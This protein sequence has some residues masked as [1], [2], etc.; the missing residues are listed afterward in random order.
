MN[1]TPG[2][3]LPIVIVAALSLFGC[4]DESAAPSDGP[5][6]VASP[7]PG[8]EAQQPSSDPVPPTGA[9]DPQDTG[10]PAMVGDEPSTTPT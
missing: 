7:D 3:I 5:M 4:S 2:S 10:E 8:G 9:A 6:I 1:R